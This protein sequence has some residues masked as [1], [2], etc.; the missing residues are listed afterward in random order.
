M[1]QQSPKS[2][3]SRGRNRKQRDWARIAQYVTATIVLGLA[4]RASFFSPRLSIQKIEVVGSRGVT[5]EDVVR[6]GGV[7][8]NANMFKVNLSRV[9]RRLKAIPCVRDAV[10]TRFLPN[11]L[12]VQIV[13]REPALVIESLDSRRRL[14]V[15]R[16]GVAFRVSRWRP[17]R[18]ELL[19]IEDKQFPKELGTRIDPQWVRRVQECADLAQREELTLERVC[20]DQDRDLWI[21]VGL[22]SRVASAS[23]MAPVR[24]K[25]D[26][27]LGSE[28]D[29]GKKF[30]AIR[31]TLK[32]YGDQI[33]HADTLNVMY[34]E[35]PT[36][37]TLSSAETPA[38]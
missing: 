15:D 10:V 7:K 37:T 2:A 17:I 33:A 36:V 14:D 18:G 21:S 3:E 13:E 6:L 31:L 35:H 9:A 25:L 20:Q 26:V 16:E 4:L 24:R 34:P 32:T 23:G 22:D 19:V 38:E 11:T 8:Y 28:N 27:R 29:L 1:S 12:R 30:R 5:V